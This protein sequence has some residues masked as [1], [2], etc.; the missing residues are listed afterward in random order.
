MEM[1]HSQ[2][3]MISISKISLNTFAFFFLC[4]VVP[5]VAHGQSGSLTLS[6]SPTLFEM[7]ANPEQEWVSTIRVVN[8]NPYDITIYTDVVNFAPQGE[9]GQ[10]KFLPILKE[11]SGGQTFAEWV[12]LEQTELTIK[13]E[14]T[15]EI[16]FKITVP[17]NAPP[18]GHF[19]AILI[20]TKSLD[21]GSGQTAVET[22]QVV[23]SL[24]FLRVTGDIIEEGIIR[25]FKG[26]QRIVEKPE[27]D[28]ELRFQNKGNVHI[29]PQGEIKIFNMWGEERGI[30]P[31]NRQTLFG[32]VLPNSIRKYSF[33]WSGEWSLADIG[34]YSVVATLAYGDGSRQFV[35][36]ETSFWVIPW[37]ITLLVIGLLVGFIAFMVWSIKL[38]VRKM[39]TLAGLTPEMQLG[40]QSHRV[41][42]RQANVSVVAPIEEGILDLRARFGDSAS[43]GEKFSSVFAIVFKYRMFFIGMILFVLFFGV[44]FWYVSTASESNRSYEVTIDGLER[45]V[46][47][48][49]EQLQYEAIKNSATTTA[50]IQEKDFPA[51]KIVNQSGVAGLAADLRIKL[52]AAGYVI[53]S[54]STDLERI[55]N[56]TVVVYAPEYSEQALALS[57]RVYGA[58]LS[59]YAE[60]SGTETPI[61]IYV[62]K[63]LENAVQ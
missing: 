60:A 11:E 57:E 15:A 58:L 62:G 43:F 7:T 17:A 28:F 13:A 6:V 18:G 34:K 23:T 12:T 45:D 5:F 39:L 29:L 26:A 63:D 10:G 9:S 51:I 8:A 24:V 46:T 14:Q 47:I 50:E 59:S 16:P 61:I 36:A 32:N 37:K 4:F 54:L 52:E 21:S 22:S 56:N 44:V 20:G 3:I 2:K 35:S 48:S 33:H 41:R 27:M 30:I 53:S 40:A 55:E 42:R 38:Y 25:E 49:S 31:V 19:G 1:I